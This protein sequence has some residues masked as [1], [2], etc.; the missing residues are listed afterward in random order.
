MTPTKPY[1]QQMLVSYTHGLLDSLLN[2][3]SIHTVE[4]D[5][6]GTYAYLCPYSGLDAKIV[7]DAQARGLDIKQVAVR[8]T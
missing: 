4:L 8:V 6:P 2:S 7:Q 1:T 3:P 5:A